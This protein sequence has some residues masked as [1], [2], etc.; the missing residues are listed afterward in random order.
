MKIKHIII[1]YFVVCNYIFFTQ[2]P[3]LDSLKL[4]LKHAKSDSVKCSILF[5]LT[6]TS[7]EEEW[8][9]YNQQLKKMVETN[10]AKNPP[11]H[12]KKIYLKYLATT[13]NNI[14]LIY[15]DE[16]NAV[17]AIENYQ[18]SLK[19][20]EEI[21]DRQGMAI[22]LINMGTVYSNIGNLN[23]SLIYCKKGLRIHIETKNKKGISYCLNNIGLI[24]DRQGDIFKAIKYYQKSLKIQEEINDKPGIAASLI[25]I[26]LIYNN[27]GDT[28]NALVYYK[29]GLQLYIQLKD[30]IGIATSFHNIGSIYDNKGLRTT[31]LWYYQ[32]ST[33]LQQMVNDK[34]GI[35]FNFINIGLIYYN[36]N[37][38]LKALNYYQKSLIINQQIQNK[39]GI[40][41]CFNS[42]GMVY[43]NQ[44]K[45]ILAL[46]YSNKSLV[47]S[48]DIGYPENIRNAASQLKTIY[49][50]LNQPKKELQM[51]EL[52][53]QMRDSLNNKETR[54]AS[55]KNLLKYEYEKK[56][57]ADSLQVAE[58]K[59]LTSIKLKQEKTQRYFLYGGL[60]LTVLFGIFMF[61]R[62]RITKKQKNI[63]SQQKIIVDE[64]QKE[65]L[66]SIH[67][68][69]RIQTSLLP[70]EKY[71]ERILK[72]KALKH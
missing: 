41:S 47:L 55:I 50:Y 67:Y 6:E 11:T 15:A 37:N 33:A 31:A 59:K 4:A 39:R 22:T 60:G 46:D 61:N 17:G 51:Y 16:S 63:I 32:Q 48:K 8:Q 58:E 68:A 24:Y 13:I 7:P 18:K 70:T 38:N 65:I 44:K 12:L 34:Q 28:S 2:T 69:K 19:I 21:Y 23:K 43:L 14:G 1:L 29:K 25:N 45:Y 54:T 71:I 66:A 35:A 9:T 5:Q 49:H 56:T 42:I 53:I 26:G 30:T 27:Q 57:V 36:Q 10:L 52:Y 3:T 64:K 40:A 20:Q 72:S 62:F